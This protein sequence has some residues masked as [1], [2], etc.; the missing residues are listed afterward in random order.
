MEPGSFQEVERL[1]DLMRDPERDFYAFTMPCDLTLVFD[2]HESIEFFKGDT[3]THF[4]RGALFLATVNSIS[5]SVSITLDGDAEIMK[6]DLELS[7]QERTAWMVA[8]MDDDVFEH[9]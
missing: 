6:R 7:D 5:H 3:V 2:G 4:G 8:N 9:W 1:V